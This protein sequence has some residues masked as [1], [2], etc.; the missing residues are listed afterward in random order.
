MLINCRTAYADYVSQ[1][2]SNAAAIYAVCPTA[3]ARLADLE[4]NH[5]YHIIAW[6]LAVW[7]ELNMDNPVSS[8][9]NIRCS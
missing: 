7:P 1:A 6:A 9:L 4:Q 2:L 8:A 5:L 3:A